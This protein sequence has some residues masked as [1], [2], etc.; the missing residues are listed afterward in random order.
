MARGQGEAPI[1]IDQTLSL[2]ASPNVALFLDVDGTLLDLAATPDT[3]SVPAGLT[4]AL[5][6]AERRLAGALALVS[7]RTIEDMDRLFEP[8][9]L[10][11][12]GVHG[13]Q[14]R[15][16]P[17]KPI[18]IAP[19]VNRLPASLETSIRRAIRHFPGLLIENKTFSLAVHY[20][21]NPEA[22]PWLRET[23]QELIVA[24][25][26]WGVEL[27]EAHCAFEL[28]LPSFNKGKSIAQFLSEPPFH[29]RRPV[30][31]GDDTTDEAGFA[32]V[33][34][35]GGQAYSVGEPR[36]GAIGFFESPQ[37]VREW[38]RAFASHERE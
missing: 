6:R 5:A 12:S 9:R 11:A 32:E 18:E 19:A 34:A 14:V 21:L 31:I 27:L 38:L 33:Q 23:L 7:G 16:Q 25:P 28:K 36:R 17:D 8:L 1:A 20:R 22:A 37:I 13:A 24:T 2:L 26:S 4:A 15:L 3:V 30:F 35:R 10:C 29:G